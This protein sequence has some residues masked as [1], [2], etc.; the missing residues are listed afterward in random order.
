MKTLRYACVLALFLVLSAAPAHA[1]SA[2]SPNLAGDWQGTVAGLR[3]TLTLESSPAAG[4]WKGKIVSLDQGNAT[5]PIDTVSFADGTLHLDLKAI[6]ASYDG[7]LNAAG[8]EFTGTWSQGGGSAPLNFRRGAASG[9]AA[10]SAAAQSGNAAKVS[11]EWRGMISTLHVILTFES[12]EGSTFAGKLLSPDQENAV[13]PVETGTVSADGSVHCELKTIGA[14]FDG[15]LSPDAQEIAG[16]WAQ[17]GNSIPLTLRRPG[18]AAPKFALTARKQGSVALEPCRTPDGNTEGLCG[19]YEVFENRESHAGRKIALNIM[20]LPALA[21]KPAADPFFPL[22]GGPGQSAVE[23][24]PLVGFT[25]RVRQQ[26]DVVLVDQRGTGHSNPLQCELRDTKD[27]QAII[28]ENVLMERLRACRTASEQKADLTQYTT[29]IFADDLDE[30]RQALGYDKINVFGGSYGTRS[31]LVYVRRHGG[32]VRTL[33]LEAVAPLEYRIPLAF[34]HTIQ[35]SIDHLIQRCGADA[36]CNADFPDLKKEFA[37]LIERLDK[38]PAQFEAKNREGSTQTVTLGRGQFIA[39]LRPILYVPEFISQFPYMIHQ[40]YLGNWDLY[41]RSALLLRETIEKAVDRGM[42]L[43]VVCAEDIPGMTEESI[44]RETSGTYLGD[45][46]VRYYQRACKEWPQGKI[47]AG[48]HE[49][50]H[51]SLPALLISGA[52]DPATPPELSAET[53]RAL[54]NS[55]VVVVKEGTHGTGSPCLDGLV[56][57]FVADGAAGGLDASCVEQI[58][59]PPFVTQKQ[60]DRMKAGAKSD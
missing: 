16:T 33:T 8:D 43:S 57:Q 14:T 35:N 12:S 31:A 23:A 44:Q 29:S 38:S 45:Y 47:P 30:V 37:E 18:S 21:E 6:G 53:A 27:T 60:I 51:S 28:G 54:S 20:I 11:G 41:G 5:I 19:K 4:Q 17:G 32:H 58:H 59:L 36:A 3:L 2:A 34:S 22:A 49:S 48:F 1:Q 52:L 9:A 55:R 24:F 56:A 10:A 26:R 13:V 39:N 15:K 40:A 50:V 42:S 46:Q 25:K 7:K